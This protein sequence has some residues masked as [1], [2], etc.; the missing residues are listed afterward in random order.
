MNRTAKILPVLL[1]LFACQSNND[2]GQLPAVG[3]DT[4]INAKNAFSTLF[5]DSTAMAAFVGNQPAGDSL[6]EQFAAFYRERNFQYAW[7]DSSGLAEQALNFWNLQENYLAYSGD[8]SIYNA[9]L[10]NLADSARNN[11]KERF[12]AVRRDHLEWQFTAQ[13]FRYAA[14]A[15]GGDSRLDAHQL[16]WFIPRRKLNYATMLDSLVKKN[17]KNITGYEPVHA[18]YQLLRKQLQRYDAIQKQGGWKT[19]DPKQKKYSRGDSLPEIRQIK[20]RLFMTGD[21]TNDDESTKY[22]STL[23]LAV[24]KFQYRYGMKQDGITGG[25]TLAEMN[26]P[27]EFRIRQIL[28]NMERIRWV[29]A[30]PT[31]DYILVNIPSFTLYAYTNNQQQL[32]MN[33]VVGSTQNSTLIF[34]GKLQHVVFS[35]YWNIPPGILRKEVLPAIRQNKNYLASHN[36]EWNGGQVRQKPSPANSLGRVKFLFPNSYSIY[37]HDTPAKSLFNEDKR[38]FSHG[39][40]RVAEP[41]KLA[42]WILRNDSIYTPDKIEAAMNAGKEKY[43]SVKQNIQVFI[44]YFTAF[45]DSDG[46]MNFR[47]DIYGHDK[48]M[49]DKMFESMK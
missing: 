37:L 17:G 26:R 22:D 11:S 3:R 18:Q 49:A 28:V 16:N 32:K 21:L 7:F 36:M 45:V 27:V 5:F 48:K 30:E 31:G 25:A 38:A 33:V 2:P 10:Q 39:C 4:G 8:S 19:L 47:D 1:L 13:F 12:T 20:H 35:P 29:P 41:K 43:V 34:T 24:K 15:Y 40:I 42:S 9:E 14:K 44:G 6:R 23:L 46:S